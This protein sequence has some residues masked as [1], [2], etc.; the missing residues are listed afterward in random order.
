MFVSAK[1]G[2]DVQCEVVGDEGTVALTPPYGL[3]VRAAGAAGG[4]AG[5]QVAGDFVPRFADA[6]PLGVGVGGR[7]VRRH[8]AGPGAREG[9]RA[10]LVAAA[11][12]E[13]LRTRGRVAVPA[14]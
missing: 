3:S 7:R 9:H 2:Y 11:G 8:V 5:V 13:S 14:D 4:V 6:Y 10:N 1:Y 12:V